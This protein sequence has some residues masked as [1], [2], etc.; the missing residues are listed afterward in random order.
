MILLRW[1]ACCWL[2][3]MTVGLKVIDRTRAKPRQDILY[4]GGELS[5]LCLEN[6]M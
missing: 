4:A 3:G 6:N 5:R 2:A 1:T